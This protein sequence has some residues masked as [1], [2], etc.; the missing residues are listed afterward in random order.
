MKKLKN[1][2]EAQVKA[3]YR[4]HAKGL[5]SCIQANVLTMFKDEKYKSQLNL[6]EID[7]I[8]EIYHL[9]KIILNNWKSKK[10]E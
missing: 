2:S 5:V 1:L 4:N 6:T 9:T 7:G 8:T 10:E 3:R